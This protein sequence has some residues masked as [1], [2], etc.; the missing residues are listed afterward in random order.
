MKGKYFK[1]TEGY[2]C[3]GKTAGELLKTTRGRT[4]I[5]PGLSAQGPPSQLSQ[6]TYNKRKTPQQ[7]QI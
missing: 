2:N 3:P 5:G 7:L 1:V 4:T 6:L